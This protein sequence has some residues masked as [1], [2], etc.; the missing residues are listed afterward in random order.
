MLR[1]EEKTRK[2]RNLFL[3][4]SRGVWHSRY[5]FQGPSGSLPGKAGRMNPIRDLQPTSTK[6]THRLKLGGILGLSSFSHL[7]FFGSLCIT[8]ITPVIYLRTC[9]SVVVNATHTDISAS[10]RFKVKDGTCFNTGAIHF[11]RSA[12]ISAC[13]GVLS[14]STISI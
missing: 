1:A 14:V 12:L 2:L 10:L 11:S 8:S 9:A 7:R 6:S 5:L 3:Q 4:Q 13:M